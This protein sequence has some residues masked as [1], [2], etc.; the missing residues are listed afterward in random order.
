[1]CLRRKCGRSVLRPQ[2]RIKAGIVRTQLE[3]VL[4][5]ENVESNSVIHG[6]AHLTQGCV[7]VSHIHARELSQ[8][9]ISYSIDIMIN[10]IFIKQLANVK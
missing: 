3:G 10:I 5:P 8:L 4:S 2:E 7:W 9:Y 6:E 1:M